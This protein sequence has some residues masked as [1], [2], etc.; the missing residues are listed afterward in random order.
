M[1]GFYDLIEDIVVLFG[2]ENGGANLLS[3]FTWQTKVGELEKLIN[4][5]QNPLSKQMMLERYIK[6]VAKAR[7]TPNARAHS[8]NVI[9]QMVGRLAETLVE[10]E[11]TIREELGASQIEL[12]RVPPEDETEE[13][14]QEYIKQMTLQKA[15]S[16]KKLK[17]KPKTEEEEVKEH[18]DIKM[19]VIEVMSGTLIRDE[20]EKIE[21][22]I[23]FV[24]TKWLMDNHIT[25]DNET[26]DTLNRKVSVMDID[27]AEQEVILRADL[28][29]P[30]STFSEMPPI[31]EEFRAFFEAQAES[32]KDSGKSKKKKKNKKQ[33]DEEAEQ[34][35]LLEQAK[36]LRS[37]PWKQ[38]QILDHR[39]I[40]RTSNILKYL[41]EHL[42]K[43]VIVLG[44]IGEKAGRAALQ[45]SMRVLINPLQHQ[46]Q[47]AQ[48]QFLGHDTIGN[49]EKIEELKENVVYV[50]ENLNFLPDEHSYVA[51]WIEPIEDNE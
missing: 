15:E 39:L 35:A 1:D 17:K 51:P 19:K 40:K 21:R 25:M 46:V 20:T 33:L 29:I 47:D 28:D 42:A 12:F 16:M 22:E 13:Q 41:Q 38:R 11:T 8:F 30:M 5:I 24:K 27:F 3:S 45:N 10:N 37:E 9:R 43:R 23:E 18:E 48:V 4:N 7:K 36:K 34:F 2:R 49:M 14:R 6:L 44:S 32:L 50:M 31:E 26:F